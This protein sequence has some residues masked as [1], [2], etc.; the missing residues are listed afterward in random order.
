M[1]RNAEWQKEEARL[2]ERLARHRKADNRYIELGVAI[3][4]QAERIERL[5][6]ETDEP[7]ARRDLLGTILDKCTVKA[8][9][10]TPTF[11]PVWESIARMAAEKTKLPTLAQLR[12][13]YEPSSQ[14]STA[15]EGQGRA[16]GGRSN[17]SRPWEAG[18][19]IERW[20]G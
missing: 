16:R 17:S 13:S 1:D 3:L 18:Y 19:E 5:Y 15:P 14:P 8:G 6:A 11:L 7:A 4:N 2:T 12:R 9:E 20:G 10:F